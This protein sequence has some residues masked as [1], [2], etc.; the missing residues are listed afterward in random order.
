MHAKVN[1]SIDVAY[2]LDRAVILVFLLLVG[3]FQFHFQFRRLWRVVHFS[4]LLQCDN[5]KI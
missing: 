2:C 1:D 5:K 4:V 3:S